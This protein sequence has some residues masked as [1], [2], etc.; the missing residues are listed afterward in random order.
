M[1][2]VN[3]IITNLLYSS[4]SD[5]QNE[6]RRFRT[7][8]SLYLIDSCFAAGCPVR[9]IFAPT[10]ELDGGYGCVCRPRF[11]GDKC[12]FQGNVFSESFQSLLNPS[13]NLPFLSL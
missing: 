6:A 13:G 11:Y 10:L 1:H 8:I 7:D 3:S 12:Q 2:L 4:T 5:K 9:G